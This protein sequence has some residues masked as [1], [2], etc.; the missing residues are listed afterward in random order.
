LHPHFDL[1]LVPWLGSAGGN[2]GDPIMVCEIGI[3]AIELGLITM[4]AGHRSLEVVGDDDVGHSTE[5]SKGPH[6]GANPVRETLRPRGFD[7]GI[8]GGAQDRNK[9]HRLTDLTGMAVD[10]RDALAGIVDKE[11]LPRAMVL[12]HD[13]VELAG[14]GAIRLA[15]PAILEALRRGGLV[16]LP[17]EEQGDA[18]AFQLVVHCGPVGSARCEGAY[19]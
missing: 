16:F 18:F 3:R 15:E 7:I 9:E 1:G 4:G 13:Q 11:L 10:D 19:G 2:H 8:V 14:P 17:Q 6:M 5:G 12:P